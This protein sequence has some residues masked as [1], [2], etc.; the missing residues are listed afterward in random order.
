MKLS[1][2][3]PIYNE[4][5]SLPRLLEELTLELGKIK[6]DWEIIA[7]DD[8]STDDTLSTL[9]QHA[10][11]ESRIRA[12]S[13]LVNSGQTAALRAGIEHATGDIIIP[14]DSDLENDPA[15]ISK[16]IAKLDEGFD[17]VSGWRYGRWQG[18]F[19]TRKIPSLLAN[20]LI[21][22]LTKTHLHDYGCTL[23][24]YR[25][26]I[27]QDVK[28]YGEMHRFIPAY[29]SW[30]G[31]RVTEIKV[32]HRP[33]KFGRSNYG[34][35]RTFRVL[36]DLLLI[37]FLHRYMN[38]PIHFFGM[39]GFISLGVGVMA[40][41]WGLY[42]KYFRE[43]SLIS[44]PL[45]TLSAL[46][47]IVGVQFMGMGILAEILMRIYYESQHKSPYTIKETINTP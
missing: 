13:F 30:R 7:V 1:I 11:K 18:S 26:A 34:I 3:V 45:P 10:K 20:K 22:L 38:R 31:A 2:V 25:S 4:S 12:I 29:A 37:K 39:A 40:G 21:S 23:K 24:A 46:L 16:L 36:L 41:L 47:I 42:L 35:S 14:I 27:L 8:G 6:C 33:R 17:V 32:N 5:Q 28:L 44:T 19:F 43:M 9:A 15:D